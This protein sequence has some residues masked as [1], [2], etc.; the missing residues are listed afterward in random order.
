VLSILAFIFGASIGS[1][2]QVIASRL[3]VAPIMK[4]RSKCL[5]CGEALRPYD[6][7]PVLSYL[8]LKGRCRYCK[9][10]YGISALV[11]EI[12]FGTVFVLLYKFILVGQPSLLVSILWLT[13]YTFLFGTLGVMAL[14]DKAH[15]YIPFSFLSSFLVLTLLML[16]IRFSEEPQVITLLSPIFVALPFLLIWLI[17]KGKGLGFGD[18]ILF[19]GVGAFFGSLQGFAVLMISVWCG[20]LVG[21]YAKYISKHRLTKTTAIPFVPFIVIAFLVVLFTGVDI[22]SIAMYFS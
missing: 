5:S 12:I 20:A 15:S 16:G 22:I 4:G 14:Y 21:V 11:I 10:T 8:L 6:L 17:T 19:F 18:V 1:F 13:Y 7:I 3:H 2:V 9:S